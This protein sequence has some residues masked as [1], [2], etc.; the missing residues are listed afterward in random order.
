MKNI[1][2]VIVEYLEQTTLNKGLA[3]YESDENKY[4]AM[5]ESLNV[6]FKFDLEFSDRAFVCHTLVH[7]DGELQL[8]HSVNIAWTNGK[9][10]RDFFQYLQEL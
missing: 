7:T 1:S 3:L 8:S 2:S 10:I 6:R 5:D 9:A 4:M